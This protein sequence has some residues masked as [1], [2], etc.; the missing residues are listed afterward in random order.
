MIFKNQLSALEDIEKCIQSDRH[1]I[2]ITGPE[3]SGKVYLANDF[4]RKHNI[5]NVVS[6]SPKVEDVRSFIGSSYSFDERVLGIFENLDNGHVSSCYSLLK[7]LEEPTANSYIVITCS[8]IRNIPDT[9]ISRSF[10]IHVSAPTSSDIVEY[11]QSLNLDKYLEFSTRLSWKV[12][13]SFE[14]VNALFNMPQDR[15]EYLEHISDIMKDCTNVS[16]L[17]WALTHYKD[18]SELPLQLS[19]RYIMCTCKDPYKLKVCLDALNDIDSKRIAV[20]SIA[21]KVAFEFRYGG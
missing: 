17:S 6:V 9:L 11:A 21:A 12:L 1:S 7:F 8:N 15:I 13:R 19:I 5:E 18:N 20:S 10:V 16:S 3:G 4:A 2:I 14:D